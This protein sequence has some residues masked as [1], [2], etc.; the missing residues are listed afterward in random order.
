MKDPLQYLRRWMCEVDR[1]SGRICEDVTGLEAESGMDQCLLRQV[2][3]RING[4]MSELA[5]IDRGILLLDHG[6]VELLDQGSS[7]K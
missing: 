6:S 7:L 5:D 3:K 2:E 1:E 4:L